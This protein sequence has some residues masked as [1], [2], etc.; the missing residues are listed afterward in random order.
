MAD[1]SRCP[2]SI[3]ELGA[4]GQRKHLRPPQAIPGAV[5]NRIE[6]RQ[7]IPEDTPGLYVTAK[8]NPRL[9]PRKRD[10]VARELAMLDH[11]PIT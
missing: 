4:L 2:P 6:R 11:T 8:A 3:N 10:E 5:A 9:L 1:T 7:S